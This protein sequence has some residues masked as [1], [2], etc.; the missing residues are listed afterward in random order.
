MKI[1]YIHVNLLKGYNMLLYFSGGM[2]LNE[3][4]EECV[5]DFW[6]TGRLGQLP[7]TS[8]NP[9]FIRAAELLKSSCSDKTQ[10]K[11]K[12]SEDYFRLFE[13]NA[14]PLAPAFESVYLKAEELPERD[15]TNESEFYNT[16]GWESTVRGKVSD[17]NLGIELLF[18]TYLIDRY[19]NLDDD[20]CRREMRKEIRRFI[21]DHLLSWIPKWNEDVQEHSRTLCYKGIGNLIYACVEDLDGLLAPE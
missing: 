21:K 14:T 20:P 7:V 12:L 2:I 19:L 16:Y 6:T 15:E 1:D 5:I 4:T 10:C 9:R 8:S 11:N 17:D 18:L 13:V 3:P